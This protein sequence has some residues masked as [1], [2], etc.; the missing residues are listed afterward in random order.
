MKVPSWTELVTLM[1]EVPDPEPTLRGVIRSVDGEDSGRQFHAYSEGTPSP[2]FAR[3]GVVGSSYRVW[4]DG[5]LIR[6]EHP[7]G[8]PS[9]IVGDELC[10]QFRTEVDGHVVVSPSGVVRYGGRG[11]D[12]LWHPSADR[13]IGPY[14]R[15]PLGPI[16]VTT[17]LDRPA[18]TVQVG[19]PVGKSFVSCWVIDAETGIQLSDLN[20]TTGAVDEWVELVVGEALPL[21]LFTWDGP[22][23]DE[24]EVRAAN[25]AEREL[26]MQGRRDWFAANVAPLPLRV[27]LELTVLV[28]E[29]DDDTGAF[30]AS[31][32]E[33]TFGQ[34]ARRPRTQE[35]WELRWSRPGYRWSDERW[36]WALDLHPEQISPAGLAALQRQ[37]GSTALPPV[38]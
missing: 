32:G 22:A 30:F 6:M 13:L 9:L 15:R 21:E 23:I 12:L 5:L 2:V 29:W 16:G 19:P 37:L 3:H 14:A 10:W 38:T 34:L 27:E 25:D 26:Q 31:V 33:T 7:D 35:P 8:T 24:A 18:W 17:F 36:D 11:T 1:V 4:R 28:H 20:E